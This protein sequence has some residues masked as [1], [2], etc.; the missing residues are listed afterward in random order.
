VVINRFTGKSKISREP[1]DA[2]KRLN[3]ATNFDVSVEVDEVP[4][5]GKDV[6]VG[7]VGMAKLGLLVLGAGAGVG[8]DNA[9]AGL[10]A[11]GAAAGA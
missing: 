7:R 1:L 9:K 5:G 3:S 6:A 4:D 8:A 2:M 10:P 11:V